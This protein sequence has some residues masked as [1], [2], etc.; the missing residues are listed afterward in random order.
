M[1]SF[2]VGICLSV[3]LATPSAFSQSQLCVTCYGDFKVSD[4]FFTSQSC[5]LHCTS[6]R[7]P[8]PALPSW[9]PPTP[10][11]LRVKKMAND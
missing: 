3:V 2:L 10:G 1:R 6:A 8:V 11:S 7:V 4:G 9:S 5:R